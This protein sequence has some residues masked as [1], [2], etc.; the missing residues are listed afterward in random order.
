MATRRTIISMALVSCLV[1]VLPAA[2]E[3]ETY[4]LVKTVEV[5]FGGIWCV[6][7]YDGQDLLVSTERD[8]FI[9]LGRY[10]LDL[11]QQGDV[12]QVVNSG[13]LPSGERVADHK[14]IFQNDYHYLTF[15]IAGGGGGGYLY[16][17]KLDRDLNRVGMVTVV[18]DDAPTN[19]MLLV[20]DGEYIYVG[21]FMP[22]QGHR[23]YKYDADLNL[24]G[25]YEIGGGPFQHSNGA[26][27]LY[28]ED[29][30]YL[31]APAT[32]APGENDMFYL[33]VFDRDWL[34]SQERRVILED[35]GMISLV[36][37]LYHREGADNFV[38]HYARGSGAEGGPLYRAVYDRDW[39]LL[40]NVMVLDG[41]YQRPHAVVVGDSLFLGSDGD[42]VSLSRFDIS[43]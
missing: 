36:T 9:Y 18:E 14:H 11:E 16:L 3:V 35:P 13:D 29:H 24:Q 5:D 26:A 37:A 41:T 30:F 17:L 20:G 19:D 39:N 32:L 43:R 42:Q 1:W 23:I 21:K 22:G 2:A 31:V 25:T 10:N 7:V 8:G 6:P 27:L 33:L 4:T 28:Y 12:Q 38:I 40:E 15:S 34:P